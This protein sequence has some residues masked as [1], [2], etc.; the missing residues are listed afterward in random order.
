MQLVSVPIMVIKGVIHTSLRVSTFQM[1]FST[2]GHQN[3]HRPQGMPTKSMNAFRKMVCWAKISIQTQRNHQAKS[4]QK[5]TKTQ[6]TSNKNP[7]NL[8]TPFSSKVFHTLSH[9]VIHF[10]W[11]VSSKHLEMEV[12]GTEDWLLIGLLPC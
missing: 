7:H 5:D 1:K 8:L 9:G 4:F 2:I 11:I 6:V 12:S 10:V 3:G